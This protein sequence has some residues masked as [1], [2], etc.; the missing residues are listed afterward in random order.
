MPPKSAVELSPHRNEIDDLLLQG[1][2][3]RFVSKYLLNEYNESISHTAIN[4][5]KKNFLNVEEQA[6][7]EYVKKKVQEKAVEKKLQ[8]NEHEEK[9]QVHVQ[10]RVSDLESL[11]NII[12]K[13]NKYSNDLDS[14]EDPVKREE[15]KIKIQSNSIR[16]NQVK[17]NI[18][19][20]EDNNVE[21]R[22]N[23]LSDLSNAIQRSREAASK[24]E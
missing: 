4:R 12:Q 7:T 1:N 10:S 23:G 16:A 15:L 20:D 17:H 22:F 21:I 9:V 2:S 14:I 11:D 8:E 24:K 13:A 18:M 6:K 5:Y 19:K 3:G